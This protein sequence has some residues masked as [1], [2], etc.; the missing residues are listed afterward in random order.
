MQRVFVG[1]VQGCGD[2][3][4]DL[5]A[6]VT[7][8]WRKDASFWFVGDLVNRGPR[9]LHVLRTVRELWEVGRA[10]VVLGN[11]EVGLLQTALGLRK[12]GRLDTIADVLDSPDL[13]E[14]VEWLCGLP[15][16]LTDRLGERRF[17]M[18]HGAAPAGW[19]LSQLKQRAR[20]VEDRLAGDG[21]ARSRFL[22]RE[23]GSKDFEV[24]ERLLTCRSVAPGGAWSASPPADGRVPWHHAWRAEQ[25]DYGVVYGHWSLQGLH[26]APGLRGLDTGCVH[27]GRGN[28]TFLTAWIPDAR[29]TDPFGVPDEGFLQIRAKRAYYSPT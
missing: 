24:F 5:I 9:N 6:E 12:L 26:V 3:L 11:H 27:S 10:R 21:V 22:A 28:E 13:A 2:E 20:A 25:P 16:A 14:W 23:R 4:D 29:A 1:D 18:I 8:R 15:V 19:S 17:A 7:R